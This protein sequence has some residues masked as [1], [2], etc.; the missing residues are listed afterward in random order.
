MRPVSSC[1]AELHV[2]EG[3]SNEREEADGRPSNQVEDGSEVWNRRRH[4]KNTTHE[5]AS[6]KNTLST[7][8]CNN[9][10]GR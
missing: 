3:G 6:K 2:E 8:P 1:R 7:K 5:D 10:N 4:E 9:Y